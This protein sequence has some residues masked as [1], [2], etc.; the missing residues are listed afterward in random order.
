MG[1]GLLSKKASI[2]IY[3]KQDHYNK[4][5]FVFD[6]NQNAANAIASTGATTGTGDN[7]SNGNTGTGGF[8]NGICGWW[9][10]QR[11]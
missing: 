9:V 7:G 5:E 8:N 2:K 1:V 4:W 10:Q 11:L 3:K 6:P